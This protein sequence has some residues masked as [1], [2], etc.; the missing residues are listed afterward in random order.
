MS[1]GDRIGGTLNFGGTE[2]PSRWRRLLGTSLGLVYLFYPITD[3]T[4]GEITGA[5][6]AWAVVA[7][8]AFTASYVATV[9]SPA[10]YGEPGRWTPGLLALTV[11]MA[12]TLPLVFGGGWLA[13]PI[14]VTVLLS[15]ALPLRRAVAGVAG[16]AVVVTAEGLVKG[17]D[18]ATIGLLLLQMTTLS[19][20]FMSVRNTR[21]LLV[22]LHRAQ[23]EV[24]R[25]AAGEERLRIARDLH[26]LLGHTL[27]LIVLKSELAGRLAEQGSPRTAAEIRD[28]EQVARTALREAREAVT[29]YR[30]RGLA[31]ELDGARAAL[32]AA[33]VAVTVRTAGTPL[34][35]EQDGLL[36]WAVREGV[37]NVVRHARARR[38][39]I[40]VAVRDGDAVLEVR[41][42]GRPGAA[43]TP[44]S[45]L[46][47]LAERVRVSGGSLDAGAAPGGGFRL[48]VVVP[49][50]VDSPT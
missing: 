3:V 13:L 28:I 6:A 45:G 47:G 9:L 10:D 8:A 37:T 23:G 17:A 18:A 22:Q 38:C 16:M 41:D 34:P 42:D 19:V 44:G 11:L 12:V 21:S 36:G 2:R 46:T 49:A 20:L 31:E 43:Y 7:L 29:G 35:D 15:M 30:R 26:D 25:L 27:S 39:E 32:D 48:R 1:L 4:S 33:G 24:A 14:Y 50:P 5:K 40:S